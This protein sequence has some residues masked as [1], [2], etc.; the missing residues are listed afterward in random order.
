[1]ALDGLS[2]I[3]IA[4][5]AICGGGCLFEVGRRHPKIFLERQQKQFVILPPATLVC[6]PPGGGVRQWCSKPYNELV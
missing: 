1:M 4:I 5:K 2:S 6:T 3:L